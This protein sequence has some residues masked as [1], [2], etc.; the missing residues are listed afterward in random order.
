[1]ANQGDF[2]EQAGMPQ[3]LVD[4]KA[5]ETE[6]QRFVQNSTGQ[7]LRLYGYELFNK[8]GSFA[9]VQ[10][11]PVPAGYILGPG[12]ELVV[13]INGLAELSEDLVIVRDGRVLIL[14]VGPLSLAGVVLNN[15]EKVLAAHIVNVVSP[16]R[17]PYQPGMKISDL[18]PDVNALIQGDY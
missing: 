9:P 15:V 10:A 3:V 16:M 4:P 14:K 2:K 6:F 8:L 17:Y 18:I 11:S 12:D 13:Q 1:M 5:E 7:A